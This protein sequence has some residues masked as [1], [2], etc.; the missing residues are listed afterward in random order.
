[1]SQLKKGAI[2][3]FVTI[4]LTN[5]IGLVLTPFMI[6]KL[7]D[8]EYGLYTLIGSLV[9]YIS[10]LDFGLNNSIVRFVA[11][12]RALEERANEEN[13]LATTMLIYGV[14]SAVIVLLGIAL[15]FNLD[16]FF[17]KLTPGEMVKAKIMFIILI[18]N[19]AITLP[20]GAFGAICS[21]YEKFVFPRALNIIK[22][23]MRSAMVVS[24]LTLGGDSISIVVMDTI[25]NVAIILIEAFYVFRRLK[26]VFKMHHFEFSLV[27]EI[28][29]YSVW[30]FVFA[31]VG[32]FQWKGGQ[33][34]LGVISGTTAVAIYAVGIMLGTY[35]GAFSTAISGVFLPRATKMT[36]LNA[37]GEELTQ[38]MVRIGRISLLVLL[39]ILG[40]FFLYGRQFVHLWLPSTYRNSW[41]I[42]LIVMI[43]YTIPLVQ[44]FANS[45]L[46]AKN[47]FSFKA[48]VYIG[49]IVLGT[50]FGA[51]LAKFYGA[52]GIILGTTTGWL[53][54]QVIMN[55]YY[56]RVIG[57]HI[58]PFFLGLV[59]GLLPTFFLILA[60]GYAISFIPG[61]DWF[62]LI[63][64]IALYAA[65]FVVLMAKFGLNKSEFQMFADFI[66]AKVRKPQ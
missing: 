30:I 57:I 43:G 63:L 34:I 48:I 19:L 14:I 55:I 28:F 2:L 49:L 53:L 46:E 15:Y 22:Y 18:F 60:F 6:Y 25:L 61:K 27:R 39:M 65:V 1:M 20:G 41:L 56:S 36:Y 5:G 54:S 21:A 3:S 17:D 40:G 8:S 50:L 12:Y 7:G 33:F 38:M 42:A 51:Y 29:A 9:G 24:L 58:V 11:R 44:A 32:Q 52:V 59:R 45:I 26:V 13:F 23:L 16:S 37:T 35:Y 31:M 64:K 10:V 62:N 4:I 47:K 66:P